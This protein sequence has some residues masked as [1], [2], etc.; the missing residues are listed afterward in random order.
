MIDHIATKLKIPLISILNVY[1][2]GS[3]LW[4]TNTD[5][6]DYD[7]Y[8]VVKGQYIKRNTHCDNIDALIVS[9]DTY[10]QLIKEHDFLTMVTLFMPT[11]TK[12][13]EKYKPKYSFNKDTFKSS[14]KEELDR[15]KIIALKHISKGNSIKANKILN[16]YNISIKV[17]DNIVNNKQ[18]FSESDN[19]V[20]TGYDVT[21][22]V[23]LINAIEF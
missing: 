8:I 16:Y 13:L 22:L 5:K 21:T 19:F 23:E 10:D 17:Y 4:K 6:S 7:Y 11:E 18:I 20:Y 9:T 14:V 1:L 3:R 2:V 12:L 15:D